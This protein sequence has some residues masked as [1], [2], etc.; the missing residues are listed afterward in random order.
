MMTWAYIAGFFDGEGTIWFPLAK[1]RG[2][3]AP[4]AS[5]F[6]T[7]ITPLKKIKEFLEVHGIKTYE[8]ST[9]LKNPISKKIIHRLQMRSKKDV[10]LFLYHISPYLIVKKKLAEDVW[11]WCKIFPIYT[12][13]QNHFRQSEVSRAYLR[14]RWQGQSAA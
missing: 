6:Q 3:M 13:E 1:K 8:Y 4:T 14:K 11:R 5:M 9:K 7:D 10:E 12:K 2:R